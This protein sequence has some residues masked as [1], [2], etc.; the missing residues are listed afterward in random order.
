VMPMS[1]T[2]AERECEAR[3]FRV[4]SFDATGALAYNGD[5]TWKGHRAAG[6]ALLG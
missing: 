4:L 6:G 2:T 3:S 5:G 1:K